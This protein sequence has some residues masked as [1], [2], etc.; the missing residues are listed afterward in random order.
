M[1]EL[2]L[3]S[4]P[5]PDEN[6]VDRILDGLG[7]NSNYQSVVEGVHNRDTLISFEALHEKLLNKELQLNRS[8]SAHPPIVNVAT[9]RWNNHHHGRRY[10]NPKPNTTTRQPPKHHRTFEGKCQ[11]CNV[12][13]HVLAYCPNFCELHPTINIPPCPSWSHYS[14][15]QA[16]IATVQSTSN[17]LL[18]S[19]AGNQSLSSIPRAYATIAILP[20]LY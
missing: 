13:G 20:T 12:K 18:D 4:H 9:S 10:S 2:A 16:H 14:M 17:W 19:G 6:L 1:D 5:I 8:I 11:W 7:E 15:P 3:L